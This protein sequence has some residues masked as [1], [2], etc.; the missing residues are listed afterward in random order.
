M[1]IYQVYSGENVL[2]QSHSFILAT[3]QSSYGTLLV[4][5]DCFF[6]S[7]LSYFNEQKNRL[8]HPINAYNR[9]LAS[10]VRSR[11]ETLLNPKFLFSQHVNIVCAPIQCQYNIFMT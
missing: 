8:K 1:Q 11:C 7:R 3:L 9:F 5:A 2:F 6:Q 4:E 10:I